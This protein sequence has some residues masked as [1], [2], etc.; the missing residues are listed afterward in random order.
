MAICHSEPRALFLFMDE[1][2]RTDQEIC[3]GQFPSHLQNKHCPFSDQGHLPRY[4]EFHGHFILR[5][6]SLDDPSLWETSCVL[7]KLGQV[8]EWAKEVSLFYPSEYGK[9]D[10][11]RCKQMFFLLLLE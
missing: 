1:E 2:P 8:D 10:L 11:Y 6:R 4:F 7:Q 5:K 9:K 3:S